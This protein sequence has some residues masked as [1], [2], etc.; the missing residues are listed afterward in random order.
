MYMYN[1]QYTYDI[2]IL[3]YNS[4]STKPPPKITAI[5]SIWSILIIKFLIKMIIFLQM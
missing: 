2:H 3:L 1:V 4:N 5:C